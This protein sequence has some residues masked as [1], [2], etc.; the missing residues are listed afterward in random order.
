MA[1]I[2][3]NAASVPEDS[4]NDF[5]PIPEGEYIAEIVDSSLKPTKAGNGMMLNLQWR[6]IDGRYTNRRIFERLN[7]VN[8]NEKAQEI[9]QRSLKRICAAVGKTECRDSV[10]LHGK[11]VKI[12]VIIRKAEGGY[13]ESNEI[14]YHSAAG[15]SAPVKSSSTQPAASVPPWQKSAA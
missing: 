3:F 5:S 1:I 14:K 10:E 4:S 9:S 13:D 15:V 8:P 7:I 2:N 11:P 12:K 6:I